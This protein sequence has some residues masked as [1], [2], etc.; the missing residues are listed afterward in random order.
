MRQPAI[1]KWL[2]GG[3]TPITAPQCFRA[4]SSPQTG[5]MRPSEAVPKVVVEPNA[6]GLDTANYP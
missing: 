4:P 6:L 3:L 1:L 5:R 2:T